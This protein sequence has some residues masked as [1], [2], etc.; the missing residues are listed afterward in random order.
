MWPLLYPAYIASTQ[1]VITEQSITGQHRTETSNFV[2]HETD[3]LQVVKLS[4]FREKIKK[5]AKLIA[6]RKLFKLKR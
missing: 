3:A 1:H 4:G 2:H 5:H 6:G